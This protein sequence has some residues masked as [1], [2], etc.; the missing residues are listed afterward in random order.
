MDSRLLILSPT[1]ARGGAEEYLLTI[2]RAATEHGWNVTVGFEL[3]TGTRTLAQ[4]VRGDSRLSYVNAP[5]GGGHRGA[6]IGQILATAGLLLRARPHVVM[7]VLPW[8]RLGI[9]S[10][11]APALAAIPT[12]VVFQLA[13]WPVPV[14]RWGPWCR[15]AQRRRQRWIA[16]SDQNGAAVVAT[17]DVPPG[18]VRTIYNGGPDPADL[19]P[20]E[21]RSARRALRDELQLPSGATVIVTVGRL[22]AQKGHED[23]LDSLATVLP[24]QPD[25]F[26]V[27]VG[28]GDLR[29]ELELQI[30]RGGLTHHVRMLG[31]RTDVDRILS[32]ADLFV[33]PSR[34]EGLPF[35]LIEAMAHGVP[36]ISS[37]AGGSPELLR[38]GIDGLIHRRED[39]ADLAEKLLWALEHPQPMSAMAVSARARAATFSEAHMGQQ[40]LAVLE[41]LRNARRRTPLSARR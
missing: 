9:G 24:E 1:P 15:W 14:G 40:T 10:M 30:R 3:S 12:A 36:S 25:A 7:V 31:H 32:A 5:I 16:V 39:P 17:F 19:N 28:D 33:L 38:D 34:F 6:V 41:Q 35:A 22:A 37:D 21:L 4:D 13:P 20:E 23:L 29:S 2:A 8:P 18:S 11:I 27:W 26:F